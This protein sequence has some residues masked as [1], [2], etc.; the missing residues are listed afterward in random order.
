MLMATREF[1]KQ[2]RVLNNQVGRVIWPGDVRHPL[3][4]ATQRLDNGLM[5]RMA[6][7]AKMEAEHGLSLAN[8]RLATRTDKCL[9]WK[10]ERDQS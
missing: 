4:L 6:M 9:T 3:S 10:Q 7:L 2:K 8:A 1:P 5:N